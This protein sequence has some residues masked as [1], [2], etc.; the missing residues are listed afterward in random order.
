MMSNAHGQA[1]CLGAAGESKPNTVDD[2]EGRTNTVPLGNY[3][4]TTDERIA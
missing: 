4:G 2:P 3:W 1:I